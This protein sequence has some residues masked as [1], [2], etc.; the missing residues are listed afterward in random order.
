[1]VCNHLLGLEPGGPEEP[2]PF[3]LILG[4][5]RALEE[6]LSEI[7]SPEPRADQTAVVLVPSG[8]E[9]LMRLRSLRP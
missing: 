8:L 7:C 4:A 1:M 5:R 9:A 2:K 6:E 3:K